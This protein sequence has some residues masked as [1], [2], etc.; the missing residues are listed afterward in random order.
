MDA[1]ISLTAQ[2]AGVRRRRAGV[3]TGM[4]ALLWSALL[5]AILA[6]LV[7]YPVA[8]LLLGALTNTNPV[9][10]GYSLADLS[11]ANFMDPVIRSAYMMTWP[12]TTLAARP[13][14]WT[15]E[16]RERKNRF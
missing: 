1:E 4:P 12:S 15:R 6:F 14:V 5:L 7:L 16:V 2:P 8:M 10:E 11:I 3:P 13:I 9:V